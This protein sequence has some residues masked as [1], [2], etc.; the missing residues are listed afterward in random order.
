MNETDVLVILNLV[1]VFLYLVVLGV[2]SARI[3]NLRRNVYRYTV[4]KCYNCDAECS[5]GFKGKWNISD[6]TEAHICLCQECFIKEASAQG[7]PNT[8]WKGTS[9][10][11]IPIESPWTK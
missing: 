10:G 2:Q 5:I 6:E 8:V 11:M 4:T 7:I 9:G 3:A 1:L